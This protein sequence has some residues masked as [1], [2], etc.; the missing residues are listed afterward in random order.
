MHAGITVDRASVKNEVVVR[1]LRYGIGGHGRIAANR[2]DGGS[3]VELP[4]RKREVQRVRS[5]EGSPGAE[6]PRPHGRRL[7]RA[8]RKARLRR[9]EGQPQTLAYG[10]VIP[11]GRGRDQRRGP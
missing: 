3:S 5:G 2:R 7:A 8:G 6:T 11:F 10:R 1:L 4:S 9:R